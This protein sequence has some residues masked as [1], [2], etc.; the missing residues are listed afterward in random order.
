L[1]ELLGCLRNGVGFVGRL[2]FAKP[3]GFASAA[4]RAGKTFCPFAL[5][6]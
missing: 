2:D 6:M 4:I 3:D 1:L 5:T